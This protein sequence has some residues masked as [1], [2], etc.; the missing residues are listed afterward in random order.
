MDY[1]RDGESCGRAHGG[2]EQALHVISVW[3]NLEELGNARSSVYYN[4]IN[5][6]HASVKTLKHHDIPK[7]FTKN[8]PEICSSSQSMYTDCPGCMDGLLLVLWSSVHRTGVDG[9]GVGE[10]AGEASTSV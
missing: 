6:M 1:L 10:Q 8:T 5:F 7:A 3:T 4:Y 2:D 9:T